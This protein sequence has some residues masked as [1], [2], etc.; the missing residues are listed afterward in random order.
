MPR[1]SH[2][3]V[4]PIKALDPVDMERVTVTDIG[5]LD[6]DRAYAIVDE[7]GEYINGKRTAAVHRLR[8]DVDLESKR[9]TLGI[10]RA[11][12]ES[13]RDTAPEREF[14]LDADQDAMEAWLSNYFEVPVTL[15]AGPGGSRTDGVVYG[16]ETRAGPTVTTEATLREVASWYDGIDPTGMRLRLRPNLVIEGTPPFWEDRLLADDGRR[17]RVGDVELEGTRPI[18][19][20]VV[21]TRDPHTGEPCERFRETFVERRAATLPAWTDRELLDDNL[22]SLTVG[23]H[24][25]DAERDGELRVGSE[26]ELL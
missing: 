21:P 6:G 15:E 14:H 2:I 26:V 20:C 12:H 25:P 4:H 18:S 19:R 13:R 17:V 7:T 22:Y 10:R 5:G 9:V 23:T 11:E 1:L 3:A 16:D 8:A 24:I